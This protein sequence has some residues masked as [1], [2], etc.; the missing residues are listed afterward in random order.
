MLSDRSPRSP[1][2]RVRAA[3]L[4]GAVAA[5]VGVAGS[6]ARGPAH[7][8]GGSGAPAFSAPLDVR[9]AFLPVVPGSVKVYS[10]RERGT[11][12]T[13]VESHLAATRTFDWGGTPVECRIVERI[14]FERGRPAETERSYLAQADDGSVWSFGEVEDSGGDGGESAPDPGGWIVGQRAAG[15]PQSTVAGARPALAMP[16]APQPGDRWSPSDSPPALV[17]HVVALTTRASV[18]GAAGRMDGVLRVRETDPSDGTHE[19][20]AFAPGVGLV[21]TRAPRERIVLQAAAIGRAR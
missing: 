19:V 20:R 18:R 5:V 12:I 7:A 9:N 16:A 6:S 15:D 13:V 4:L 3:A 11:P 14:T 10:G 1:S 17:K 8:E 21:S 2:L